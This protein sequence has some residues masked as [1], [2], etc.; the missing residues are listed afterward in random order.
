MG[1]QLSTDKDEQG[2]DEQLKPDEDD[3]QMSTAN[4]KNKM[5]I[6]GEG[7]FDE[8]LAIVMQKIADIDTIVMKTDRAVDF[9]ER[10][11]DV[12]ETLKA[13]MDE[14]EPFVAYLKDELVDILRKQMNAEKDE[15]TGCNYDSFNMVGKGKK[16]K[17]SKGK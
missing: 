17:L 4:D 11:L 9:T 15:D 2:Y 3:M 13:R 1:T 7:I 8:Q 12:T 5:D 6:E 14:V 16:G 10:L